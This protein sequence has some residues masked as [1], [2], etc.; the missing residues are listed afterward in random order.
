[1]TNSRGGK[2]EIGWILIEIKS[3]NHN[4]Q[5]KEEQAHSKNRKIYA[6]KTCWAYNWNNKSRKPVNSIPRVYVI[7]LQESL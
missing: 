2:C 6:L 3:I 5:F 1:M 4:Y 7:E